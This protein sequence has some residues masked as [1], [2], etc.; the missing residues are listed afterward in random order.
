MRNA[1]DETGGKA[2]RWVRVVV[3]AGVMMGAVSAW[4][5]GPRFITGT[6]GY[7]VA[8]VPMAWYTNAPLYFTDPG[9]WRQ[10]RRCGIFQRRV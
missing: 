5:G 2:R 10:R 7:A 4:A 6:T 8:G 9:D 1:R 3:A